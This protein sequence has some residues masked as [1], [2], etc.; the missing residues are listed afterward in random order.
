M[1]D[2]KKLIEELKQSGMIAD[3]EYGNAMVDMI[4]NQPKI[5]EWIPCSERLPEGENQKVIVSAIWDGYESTTQS[6]FYHGKFYNK[7]YYQI[8]AGEIQESYTGDK[9]VAW[10]HLPAP[11]EFESDE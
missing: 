3:N 9:V 5:G 11:Y 1:I 8:P 10:Q 7:P 4:E 2:E 6:Y